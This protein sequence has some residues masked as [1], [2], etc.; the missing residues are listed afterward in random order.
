MG[1]RRTTAALLLAIAALA[2][3]GNDDAD[4]ENAYV[5]A[6]A[7][8]QRA[9]VSRFDETAAKLTPTSSVAQDRVTLGAFGAATQ[10]VVE[11][12]RGIE[13]PAAVREEHDRLV[14]VLVGYQRQVADARKR[15][16]EGT[17]AQRARA[18]T[19]LTAGVEATQK[20]LTD[21][22]TAINSELQG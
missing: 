12:L 21:A 13:P 8:A 1:S 9:Y 15:L 5:D 22:I 2:G 11:A 14:G 3:C 18:R 6:V 20:R 10:T 19:E 4:A 7:T 16:G 17:A